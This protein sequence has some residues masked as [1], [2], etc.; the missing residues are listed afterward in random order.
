MSI[1]CCKTPV[2]L[3]ML[4]ISWKYINKQHCQYGRPIFQ[5]EN[6]LQKQP[7]TQ[8]VSTNLS[9]KQSD[10]QD[11]TNNNN[12]NHLFAKKQNANILQY[13]GFS[14]E[15]LVPLVFD[16]LC[17]PVAIN[18]WTTSMCGQLQSNRYRCVCN[19][20]SKLQTFPIEL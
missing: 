18:S 10:L 13:C 19:K 11:L 20:W 16:L 14:V 1:H 15:L 5:K 6:S 8:R 17:G 4:N 3:A 2:Y 7:S 9:C 12:S